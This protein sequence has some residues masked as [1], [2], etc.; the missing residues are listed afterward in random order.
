MLRKY[1]AI[2][3]VLCLLGAI[4][5]IY[6]SRALADLSVF[7]PADNVFEVKLILAPDTI[8]PGNQE[9]E[10]IAARPVIAR[11]LDKLE[12][13]GPYNLVIRNGYLE[14]TLPQGQN[15]PYIASVL[16]SV[17]EITFIGSKEWPLPGEVVNPEAQL[18]DRSRGAILFTSREVTEITPPDSTSG[19][20]FYRLTLEPAAAERLADF[21]AVNQGA[22]ICMVLDE[23]V[24]NCSTMYHQANQELEILPEFSSGDPINMT[25]LE[26]FLYSGPLSTRLKVLA[27]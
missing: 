5:L 15:I 16:T 17:G 26:V 11:R 21:Q 12:L 25:D 3:V 19:Q 13:N 23:Q 4:S 9:V 24:I 22:Y 27:D 1:L 2:L 8:I 14:V 6:G 18:G 20:I 7:D 10:L